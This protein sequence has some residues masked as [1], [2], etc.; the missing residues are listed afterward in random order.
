[1]SNEEEEG[2]QAKR[3]RWIDWIRVARV[4][5]RTSNRSQQD[6]S[7]PYRN[8]RICTEREAERI[9]DPTS[10]SVLQLSDLSSL[11]LR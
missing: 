10:Q 4:I 1:M 9:R 3:I 5:G 7:N 6:S 8:Q 2:V 11:Q